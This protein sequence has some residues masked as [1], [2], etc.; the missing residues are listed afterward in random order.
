M[1]SGPPGYEGVTNS[2]VFADNMSALMLGRE[3]FVK[4]ESSHIL[5]KALK[6]KIHARGENIVEGDNIYFK[7][8]KEK[9]W[10]GPVKV[11][12]VNGKKLFVDQGGHQSTVNRDV[13]I[14]VGEEF[15]SM[16]GLNDD[17]ALDIGEN[18]S[19]TPPIQNVDGVVGV[20][21]THEDLENA[22]EDQNPVGTDVQDAIPAVPDARNAEDVV[23]EEPGNFIDHKDIKKGDSLKFVHEDSDGV[24]EGKVLSRAGKA[25]GKH[26]FWWN[27]ENTTTGDQKSFDTSK[28]QTIEKIQGEEDSVEEVFVVQVPRY[29]HNQ[30]H[31]I[32]AK[33]KELTSWDEFQVYDEVPDTGQDCLGTNWMLTEKVIDGRLSVKARLCVRGD[34]E[35]ETFRTDSPTVHKSSINIFFM[36]AAKNKWQI[37]TSDIK[38]AFLQGEAIDR[39]VYVKPPKER[40][41]KGIV[42]K[43]LKRAYGLT[44]AS[45][46]FFLE[47]CKTLVKLGCKQSRYDPAMY[48][49]YNENGGLE[50]MVLTHVDDLLHGSGTSLFYNNIMGPLKE[51]FKFG[52]EEKSEFRYVGMQVK[53][54]KDFISVNQ[55]HYVMSMEIP[56]PH[57]GDDNDLLD[58]EGQSEFRSLLG[59]IGWLGNHSRPDLV[60]DHIALSTRIGKATIGDMN[61]GLKIARKLLSSTTEMKFPALG[62]ISNWIMEVYADAGFRSLPDGVSSCGGQVVVMRDASSNNACVLSWRGRKL[63]RIVTSST[64]AETLALNDL[65]SEVVFVKSVL[66]EILGPDVMQIPINTYTDAKNVKRSVYS[67]SLVEDP[68][69]RIE[70]ATLQ[71]SIEKGELNQLACIPG[72]HMIANCLTKKGASA[73]DLLSIL[74]NGY[75]SDPMINIV[76]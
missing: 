29:L 14:R 38:C 32:E 33:E 28:F 64:A 4:A 11:V 15:W 19:E 48:L 75:L 71:E 68:R 6:S 62:N 22:D 46:G 42:W 40:R 8:G 18:P 12:G 26:K 13:A 36:L 57:Q 66:S 69:L 70:I 59:R 50:G 24:V 21:M 1:N 51:K 20:D 25:G 41:I 43:M 55:D 35:K 10:R 65:I 34:Q 53:Q 60:F 61:Q 30:P 17:D 73:K 52:S 45:R 5:K 2:K 56:D 27:I 23:V 58:E 47:L 54:S 37:Q 76:M 3:E 44:D 72:K 67:T 16:D 7:K 9:V 31:C 39:E 74:Q 63:K 49:Y